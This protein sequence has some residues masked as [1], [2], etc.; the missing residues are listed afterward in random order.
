MNRDQVR[1]MLQA[2]CRELADFLDSLSSADWDEASLCEGWTVREVTAHLASVVGLS[3]RGLVGRAVRYGTGTDGANERS[4][5]AYARKSPTDLVRSIGDPARL[6]L[7][8]FYPRWALCE[9]V[10]HHQDI[11]RGL[12]RP[13]SIPAER[14]EVAIDVLLRMSFLTPRQG[15]PKRVALVATDTGLRRG[16]GPELRGSAEA[17]LM[18]LAGRDSVLSEIA[19]PN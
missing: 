10:V 3:R 14:V 17:L 2:E 1:A 4:A 15:I 9:T 5:L 16:E 8:F 19:W 6:G 18:S 12:C 11:R 13:R 7:G